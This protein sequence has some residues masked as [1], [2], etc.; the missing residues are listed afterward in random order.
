MLDG[1][2]SDEQYMKELYERFLKGV[3]DNDNSEFYEKDELLDIYDYAQDEG[4]EMTQLYVLLTGARLYPDSDFLDERKA[5]LLSAINEES[6]RRMFSR[7]G[8]RDS[9]LWQ[10]LKLSLDT[11]PDGNPEEGLAALLSSDFKLPCEAVIRLIDMLRD[12]GRLD[13]LAENLHVIAD[14]CTVPNILMYEAAEA[15]YSDENYLPMARDIAEELTTNE[16]FNPDNWVLLAKME[17]AM[18]HASECVAA[19]DYALAIDPENER[20]MLIK[21]LG[22]IQQPSK[23]NQT[24]AGSDATERSADIDRG[25]ALLQE[26]LRI[27]PDNSLAV[28][29]LS[30]GYVA[31]D[32]RMAALEVLGSYMERDEAN[33]YV[34][35]DVLKLRPD[36]ASRFFEVFDRY[37]GAAERK[38]LEL[39]AQVVNNGCVVQ[40]ADLLK[41]YNDRHVLH[42]GMEYYLQLLYRLRRFDDYVSLFG[43]CCSAAAKPGGIRYDFSGNAYLLLAASY[44]MS[45]HFDEAVELCEFMLKDPPKANDFDEHIRWKGMQVVLS[46]IRNLARQKSPVITQDG[47]DPVTYNVSVG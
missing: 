41:F 17:F 2:P 39:A 31:K 7:R 25:I 15:L 45:R 44:L 46:F 8:R 33:A 42:E 20:G 4:D 1:Q 19:A 3:V 23:E 9:A 6:A 18:Q 36:D 11:Y 16:P 40:A 30:E 5:F 32:N 26:V 12:L 43:D 47:F 37:T 29:A 34:L 38:W 22:L 24:V 10:V 14:R 13:L 28:K 35:L 21:G 27:N